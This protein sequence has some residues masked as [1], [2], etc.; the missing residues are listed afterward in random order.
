MVPAGDCN[1]DL[2]IELVYFEIGISHDTKNVSCKKILIQ[3]KK[4]GRVHDKN[5]NQIK[6]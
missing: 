5:I 4:F 2:V 6:T 3:T 1:I